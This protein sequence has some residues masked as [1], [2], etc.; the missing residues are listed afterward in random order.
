MKANELPI[1]N[2]LQSPS[3]QFVIPV[4]QR[5][6]DWTT[7]QCSQLANDIIN[8]EKEDRGTH[9]IGSIV[10]IHEGAYSTSEVKEL[11]IIDGQQRLTTINILYVALYRFAKENNLDK[12]AEMLYNMFLVN[13]YVQNESSKLKLKQTD[14]NSLA[15]KSILNST[16]NQF[17]SY[18]NVIENFNFFKDLIN[19]E[20]FHTIINGIKRLIFVEISLERDKDD[21]QRIFESLNSTG[22]DLSQS[23]L[24]R[25]FILMDLVPKE[26]NK[27][28]NNIWSPIEENARD[29]TKQRSLVSSY[30]RD[31]LTLKS[32][33]IP[34]KNKVYVEFKK[35]Y[36]DYS[37]DD[38]NQELEFI[39]LLSSHYKKFINPNTENDPE[40]RRE[41]QYISR[42]EINVAYPFL[43]QVFEDYE[44]GII[45]KYDL[46][47][48]LK[49]IQSFTWRRFVVGLPTNALN[50]I[51]MALYSDIDHED[52]YE[53]LAVSLAKKK[54][55]SRFPT[56]QDIE[57]S[58]KEKDLYN[59]QSKNRNYMFEMLENYNNREYVDTA[60]EKIT[61]EHI[62][63]RNPN[64]DW[65]DILSNYELNDFK[66]KYLNTIGNLTLSGN[67]GALSNKGFK[68]KKNMN[69]NGGEQG[70]VFSRMW[71]NDYLK[72]IDTWSTVEYLD[73]QKIIYERF[74]KIWEYP[75]VDL[76]KFDVYDEE[77]IFDV[78]DPTNKKLQYF[79]FEN[80]KVEAYDITELYMYVMNE[81]FERNAQLLL[82]ADAGYY[83][84][85]Q[86][87]ESN[88]RSAKHLKN[89]YSVEC[90]MNSH[91]K[92]KILRKILSLFN[93]DDLSVKLVPYDDAETSDR[94]TIRKTF[95]KEL[96]SKLSDTNLYS[97]TSPSKA[98][99]L[100]S[101]SGI[102]GIPYTLTITAKYASIQL[103]IERVSKQENKLIYA[104]FLEN[105]TQIELRFGDKLIWEE[106]LDKKTSRVKFMIDNVNLYNKDDWSKLIDFFTTNLPKFEQALS[107]E[108]DKL[109]SVKW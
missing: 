76:S 69:I 33:K 68:E 102:S 61:I 30:I 73:R 25:N 74:L 35:K 105:K 100:N 22:L 12:D 108:I 11:V 48:V 15:F 55:S 42:L 40:I 107:P 63:P 64:E 94:F 3:V 8:V 20:N 31:Y 62:F 81:L 54:G 70:Y 50:K 19:S 7:S 59:I 27:I 37:D 88:L 83:F 78:E 9:F 18:S 45:E 75:D 82:D 1:N 80:S 10:F 53:S 17:S 89:G 26:Q 103:T 99:W 91:N 5:N 21:P 29:L 6:Y 86:K 60:N 93:I 46:I 104:R 84:K 16:E 66:D 85:I 51:F 39:K 41:L 52:Y 95:W 28:F 109:K 23:D 57:T 43:L 96:L 87:E 72:S 56:N 2:F 58:L 14:V 77:N 90:G 34:N 36:A 67:N 97:N 71:L 98:N 13:Q 32:K 65:Q 4:Y 24:I 49:L 106:M 92:F 38:F 47:K 101:G 44:N 79:I